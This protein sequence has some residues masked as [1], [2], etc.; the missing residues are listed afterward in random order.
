MTQP[1][2]GIGATLGLGAE[3]TYGTGV[4]PTRWTEFD[5]EK[6]VWQPNRYQGKGISGTLTPK[7]S[8]RV[9]TTADAGGTI[10]TQ[11]FT[12]GFGLWLAHLLGS[13]AVPVQQAA[14]TAYKQTHLFG[15]NQ[16][17]SLTVQKQVIDTTRASHPY[18]A[19]GV[20][21]LEG[22]FQCTQ[23]QPLTAT[24]TVDAKD[25]IES[26]VL[27]APVFQASN[28]EFHFGQLA[29]SIGAFGSEAVVEGVKNVQ[30]DIKRPM[31]TK[32][33]YA[34][35]SG[36]KQEPIQNDKVQI[37]GQLD[38]D[39]IDKTKFVDLFASG[40]AQ[41]LILTWTSTA[42]AGTAIPFSLSVAFPAVYFDA[43]SPTVDSGDVVAPQMKFTA[44]DDETHNICTVTY[45]STDT[46]L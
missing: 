34:D 2:A 27:T 6:V 10:K 26:Q 46:T 42:L 36:R 11:V 23:D 33:F 37:N 40:A 28:P 9:T 20:K 3:S 12:K 13:T 35:G 22:Q 15:D 43:A 38:T 44:L 7:G 31:N 41:S 24:F 29:V 32:R 1:G 5:Q 39:F 17:L 25:L 21:L 4:P 16:G 45:M 8:Q 14:T 19:T 18:T 30:F